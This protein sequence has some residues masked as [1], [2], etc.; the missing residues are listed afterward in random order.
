[1]TQNKNQHMINH[2][3]II[4]LF[5]VFFSF[6]VALWWTSLTFLSHKIAEKKSVWTVPL[7]VASDLN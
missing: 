6:S 1:M 4:L 3:H 5:F 2:T 7:L